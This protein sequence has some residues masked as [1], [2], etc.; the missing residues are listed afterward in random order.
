M[1]PWL[2]GRRGGLFVFA[3]IAAL[4]AGALG[5]ASHAALALENE[6]KRQAA[7][8]E[9]A[10]RIRLALWRLDRPMTDVLALEAARPFSHY[11]A[12][13]AP[14]LALDPTGKVLPPGAV[15][16]LSPLL[17]ADLPDWML[18]HFQTDESGW[19]SP[20]V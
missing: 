1:K 19:E 5:W 11:S 14:P 10:D 12:L 6:Q 15:L 9:R 7:A 3:L 16:Q 17:W 13:H 2:C 18:L 4:V 8:S 20:Q